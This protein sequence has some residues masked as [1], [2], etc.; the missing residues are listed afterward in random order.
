[1]GHQSYEPMH[2]NAYNK[3]RKEKKRKV[4]NTSNP[5]YR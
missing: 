1:M 2:N 5:H 3:E 4:D